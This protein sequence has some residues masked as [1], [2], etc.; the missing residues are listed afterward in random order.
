MGMG[1]LVW[2][3]V[4]VSLVML[5]WAILR[6]VGFKRAVNGSSLSAGRA[7]EGL[8]F[9]LGPVA[10]IPLSRATLILFDCTKLP[11]GEYRLDADLGEKCFGSMWWSLFPAGIAG[12]VL[13][14][15]LVPGYI[16]FV[17]YRNREVLFT[18][19]MVLARFGGLYKLYRRRFFYA[20]IALLG[21]RL[22]IVCASLFFSDLQLWLVF[23]LLVVFLGSAFIEVDLILSIPLLLG[24]AFYSDKFPSAES[25][26]VLMVCS[27][28][29]VIAGII[30]L[31]VSLI[32]EL[33][34]RK[35]GA[36]DES[37]IAQDR[38]W[39]QL[40]HDAPDWTD[41]DT[42]L[43]IMA[44]RHQKPVSEIPVGVSELEP[45]PPLQEKPVSSSTYS[46]SSSVSSS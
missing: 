45:L 20:E 44:L 12:V 19:A 3:L 30:A 13:Y 11:N 41:R 14:V 28:L 24:F 37:D 10:Y 40:Q 21:K 4:L 31:L 6:V 29:A 9:A 17:L 46:G 34:D 22:G 43:N 32:R 18:D 33:L 35:K 26:D 16:A 38:F 8:V 5:C 15:L 39:S 42:L 27:I 2:P 23:G 7:L 25:R 1:G 36:N